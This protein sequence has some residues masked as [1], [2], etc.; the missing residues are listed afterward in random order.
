M[1]SFLIAA[2]VSVALCSA[3][4]AESLA[5]IEAFVT[6]VTEKLPVRFESRPMI[7]GDAVFTTALPGDVYAY[8]RFFW[9]VDNIEG[10]C[11]FLGQ[12][13]NIEMVPQE[14][15]VRMVGPAM[16]E[17][18]PDRG[19]FMRIYEMFDS[20]VEPIGETD[21]CASMY[22]LLGPNGSLMPAAIA[23]NRL[24]D[25]DDLKRWEVATKDGVLWSSKDYCER[26]YYLEPPGD[27]AWHDSICAEADEQ[28]F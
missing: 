2:V 10:V 19:E 24:I 13:S 12:R 25:P 8:A 7:H 11:S 17:D 14:V 26:R 22:R 1:K 23:I 20:S 28:P 27:Q 18:H 9:T 5:K 21:L 15:N 3:A 6:E 16:N 4:M